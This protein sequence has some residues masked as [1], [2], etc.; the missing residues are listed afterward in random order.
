MDINDKFIEN[1]LNTERNNIKNSDL[2]AD[3]KEEKEKIKMILDSLKIY[4]IELKS[5]YNN[6]EC[7]SLANNF[8]KDITFIYNFPNVYYLDISG[9]HIEN[10]KPLM[11]NGTFGFL[12][13]SP[14]L[15]YFEKKILSLKQMNII[16]FKADI[17]DRTIYSGF[18]A[19]NPNVLVFNNE[20]INFRQKIKNFY[21]VLRL[22]FYVQ[23]LFWDKK[24]MFLIKKE[25]NDS[26]IKDID[27]K[28][29]SNIKDI[30]MGSKLK[31]KQ[32]PITNPKCI[33]IVNFFEKYNKALFDI[34]K[35]NTTNFNNEILYKEERS[36][37]LMIYN[38]LNNLSKIFDVNDNISSDKFLKDAKVKINQLKSEYPKINVDIFSHLAFLQY[39]EFVLSNLMLYLLNIFSK[40]ITLYLIILIFKKTKFYHE[41]QNNKFII[42]NNI[43]LLLGINKSYLFSFYYRIYDI[44]FDRSEKIVDGEQSYNAQKRLNMLSI[45]DKINE[46]LSHENLFINACN[47][48]DNVSQRNKTIIKNFIEFLYDVKIFHLIFNIFQFVNDFIIYNKLF[49][50]LK[51]FF[52]KDI[53][54]FS[55]IHGLLLIYYNKGNEIKESMADKKYNKIQNDF[56]LRNKFY[57][58]NYNNTRK[59]EIFLINP[60]KVYRAN[61]KKIE[62]IE[63]GKSSN[64]LRKEREILFKQNYINNALKNYLIIKSG[65]KNKKDIYNLKIEINNQIGNRFK[66]NYQKEKIQNQMFKTF[67]SFNI[68]KDNGINLINSN[69]KYRTFYNS[70]RGNHLPSNKKIL[71]KQKPLNMTIDKNEKKKRIFNNYL[72]SNHLNSYNRNGFF[73]NDK[74]VN[75]INIIHSNNIRNDKDSSSYNENENEIEKEINQY[76]L[77]IDKKNNKRYYSIKQFKRGNIISNFY[78]INNGKLEKMKNNFN[79]NDSKTFEPTKDASDFV[80]LN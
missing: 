78:N 48:T 2:K 20:I 7:L 16:I 28:N 24:E 80:F 33:E 79:T 56:L 12:S 39:K 11:R 67:N 76:S 6:I 10:F 51:K 66:S 73:F 5:N 52:P 8:I 29:S 32:K 4:S 59:R 37:F 35:S 61:K 63:N 13:I 27:I 17:K 19:E 14:P 30:I 34:F 54:F 64:D 55:E 18:L 3:E 41:C 49:D 72:L 21:M 77:T 42:E 69:L 43:Q 31:I 47:S 36:K 74:K 62:I 50:P 45:T 57:F 65:K 22:K 60:H 71:I 1:Y 26:D 68:N 40:D 15:N 70:K 9:N 25:L 75:D 46:I 53:Q 58:S 23:N 38:T 44:L